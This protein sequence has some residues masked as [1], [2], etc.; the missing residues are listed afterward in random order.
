M[1]R[2]RY[3]ISVS[4]R[5]DFVDVKASGNDARS[6]VSVELREGIEGVGPSKIDRRVVETCL[7]YC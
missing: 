1:I 7:D 4:C 3:V 6:A 5:S 2:I